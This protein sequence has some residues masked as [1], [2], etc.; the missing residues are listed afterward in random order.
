[1]SPRL[2]SIG[3]NPILPALVALFVASAAFSEPRLSATPRVLFGG[4][5]VDVRWSGLC[6]R[7][8]QSNEAELLLSLDG[9]LTF[10]IRV[11][12]EL[13]P[14]ASSFRWSVPS[15]PT[16]HGRLALRIGFDGEA[17]RERLELVGDEFTILASEEETLIRAGTE[18]WTR[19]ALTDFSAVDLLGDASDLS[20]E[21]LVAPD[22]TVDISDRVNAASLDSGRRAPR[23]ESLPD[24]RVAVP[25][26][27]AAGGEIAALPL[28]E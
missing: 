3:R 4:S 5:T 26:P 9:G 17:A 25:S 11:S 7:R 10:P 23:R 6:E 27:P 22:L 8:S 28:R 12:P 20:P 13:S 18:W 19:Q 1:M 2:R 16:P 21:R 15:L 24:T 14:C